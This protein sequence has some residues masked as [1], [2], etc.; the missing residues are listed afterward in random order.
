MTGRDDNI[1]IGLPQVY[2]MILKLDVKLDKSDEANRE[3]DEAN[4]KEIRG[5]IKGNGK[6][7]LETRES[8]S[9]QNIKILYWLMGINITALLSI[10]V[11]VIRTGL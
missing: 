5:W 11:F 10:A 9:E 8:K 7:G 1:V 3:R 2:E 4:Q 6:D